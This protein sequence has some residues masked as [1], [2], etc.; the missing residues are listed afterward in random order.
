MYIQ[1]RIM[2]IFKW[3][4]SWSLGRNRHASRRLIASSQTDSWFAGAR[5]HQVGW[6]ARYMLVWIES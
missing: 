4:S 5:A 2:K 6:M 3:T 1:V